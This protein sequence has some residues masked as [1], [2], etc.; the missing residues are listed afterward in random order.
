MSSQGTGSSGGPEEVPSAAAGRTAFDSHLFALA[1]HCGASHPGL[2]SLH[3]RALCACHAL[4]GSLM[5]EAQA[6]TAEV[7]GGSC[8]VEPLLSAKGGIIFLNV[9]KGW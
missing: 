8:H 3:T 1:S 2:L 9:E 4:P 7:N 5:L 6:C